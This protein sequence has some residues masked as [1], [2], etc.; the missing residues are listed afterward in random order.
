MPDT[1]DAPKI[2]FHVPSADRRGS[3]GGSKRIIG[4]KE[5]TGRKCINVC[6]AESKW[7][8]GSPREH[9]VFKLSN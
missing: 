8:D 3:T 5:G 2:W 1:R 7:Q 6:L 9:C 4:R